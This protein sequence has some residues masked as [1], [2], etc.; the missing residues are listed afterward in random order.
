MTQGLVVERHRRVSSLVACE[1]AH[2][3]AASNGRRMVDAA[4][5]SR[6]TSLS[7]DGGP[8]RRKAGDARMGGNVRRE[9][10]AVTGNVWSWGE[11]SGY[12]G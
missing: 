7:I 3:I 4:S 2:G 1:W 10:K 5:N 12:G 9:R 8:G 6:H 11:M